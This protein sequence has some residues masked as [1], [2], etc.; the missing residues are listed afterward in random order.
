MGIRCSCG[1]ENGLSD[2]FIE[3]KFSFEFCDHITTFLLYLIELPDRNFQKYVDD[4]VPKAIRNQYILNYLFEKGLIIKNEDETI[5]CSQFGKLII[6]LYL[7]PVSGV[8]I[9]HKLENNVRTKSN[10]PI[11]IKAM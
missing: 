8:L 6:R 3:Q 5:K 4:I 2:N 9:R 1:F 11:R 10:S 7:Y